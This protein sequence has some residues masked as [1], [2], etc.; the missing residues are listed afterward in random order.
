MMASETGDEKI[1]H[2]I[3]KHVV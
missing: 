2:V 1:R 3:D